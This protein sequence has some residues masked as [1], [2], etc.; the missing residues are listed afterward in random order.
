MTERIRLFFFEQNG[1]HTRGDRRYGIG[2]V[3][4][5][6]QSNGYVVADLHVDQRAEQRS[7]GRIER[8]P[9]R[10]LRA[11][12]RKDGTEPR[13]NEPIA[14]LLGGGCVDGKID[15]SS[16]ELGGFAGTE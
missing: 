3:F 9:D 4:I 5:G 8:K 2:F 7:V 1:V 12:F 16:V 13:E 15:G 14:D 10:Q 11:V 6:K